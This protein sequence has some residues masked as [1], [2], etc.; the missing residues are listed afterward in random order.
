MKFGAPFQKNP[1]NLYFELT[2]HEYIRFSDIVGTLLFLLIP[3]RVA[4][5][6]LELSHI[7]Y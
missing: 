2:K 1:Y 7:F 3:Q 6:P 5:S 4:E